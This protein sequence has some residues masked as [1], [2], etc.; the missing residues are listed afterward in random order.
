MTGTNR[1]E[2]LTRDRPWREENTAEGS[3]EG[4]KWSGWAE[5]EEGEQIYVGT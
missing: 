3:M 5:E 1:D 4:V 2:S